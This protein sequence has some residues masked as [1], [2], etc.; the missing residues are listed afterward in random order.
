MKYKFS[1]VI[2]IALCLLVHFSLQAQT[3]QGYS[4]LA[5]ALRS[6]SNLSGNQGPQS[7]NW[8]NGGNKYSYISNDEIHSMDPQTL[9]DELIFKNQGLNFPGSSTAFNYESFQWSHDSKHL[10]FKT[11]FRPIY[12]RSGISDVSSHATIETKI[13]RAHV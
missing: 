12:R 5:E 8:T 13:G 6:G 1:P 3:K 11:N 7:V 9:K 10:V 4:S 2:L